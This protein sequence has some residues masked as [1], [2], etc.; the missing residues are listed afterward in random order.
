MKKILTLLILF[1]T[2]F[3]CAQNTGITYQAVIYGPNGQQVPGANNQ[4][5]ILANKTI[6]LQFSIIDQQGQ[7]EYQETIVTTTDK[8][9]MVNLLI[10]VGNQQSGYANGFNDILWNANTKSLKVELDPTQACR[11]FSVISNNPFTYV[12]FAFHSLNPGNPGPQ[13]EQGPIGLT[14]PEGPQGE[15][16]PIG[17]TGP[18][19]PQGEQGP[20]GLT[21]PEGPQGEQG[22]IGLTGPEG[23]QGEQ[24]PIGLTG[25][26]GP[27][28]EQ[29]PIG[30]TGPEGPQGEQ[31]PIGLT[32][33]EGPQGEQGPI[34]L[35]GPEGPQGEQ[36]P[37]GLTGPEGP[38]GEQGPIGLTGPEGPQGEQGP[39]GLTGPEGPQGEQGPIGLTGPEGPQGEQGPIGLTGPEGP[40]GEQG[41]IGL[42][43]PEGPQ[44]EQGPIGLT[45]PEGPQGEQG[46]E[47]LLTSGADAG[48]T[49][50]WDG[51][52]WVVNNSN[53]HNDGAG[54]GIGTTTPN[55]SA[56]VE[57][58]S[59]TQGF[60]PPRLTTVQRDAIA[61][62][63]AGLTIYNTTVNCLQWWNGSIWYD[64]CGNNDPAQNQYP[65]NSVFCA[66]GPTAIVDV[67]NPST[68]KIWMDRNLGASQAAASSADA[69]SYGDLYQW[70][71]R[72]DG[73]QCRN[74]A[75]TTTLSST[76]QPAHGNFI[77]ALNS[78]TDW[79]SPQNAN[80]WQGVNG[81]NNPCP[82]GY[83]LPTEP[84]LDA[85]RLSWGS[86]NAAG[87]FASPL[88]LPMAGYRDNGLGSL[89]NVGTNGSYWSSGLVGG[90]SPYLVF[91]NITSFV[92]SNGRANGYSVRCLKDTTPPAGILGSLDCTSA[93]NNGTLTAGEAASGVNSVVPYTGGNAG[94]HNGQTI[95]STGVTGLTATLS[96]G[97]FA[98]GAGSL[99]YTISGT[100]SSSGTANFALNIGGQSCTLTRTVSLSVGTISSLSCETATN[101]G[102]LT[103]GTTA[104]GVSSSVP[105]TGGNGGTHSGQIV[106]STG[107]TGLTATLSPG[108]FAN[109]V[110][111]LNYTI[112][113]TPNS[114]GTASFAL[115]IGGQECTI[116]I[117]VSGSN[118]NISFLDCDNTINSGGIQV[119]NSFFLM[120][121]I[122]I[123]INLTSE[124]IYLG[125]DGSNYNQITVNSTGVLGLTAFLEAGNF[126]F[127]SGSVTFTITG[128]PQSAGTAN[129]QV[130]IGGIPCSFSWEVVQ[131]ISNSYPNGSVF[132]ASGPT[133]I[134][135]R[136]SLTGKTWMDR[137]LGAT[138]VATSSTDANSG[139]D[140]Y[141]WG[142]RSDGHQCRN[143]AV[144]TTGSGTDQPAHGDFIKRISPPYDW[145]SPQN[146]NLWQGVNGVNN[147]CPSGYRLPTEFELSEERAS[148]SSDDAAGAFG[149]PLKL[150]EAGRRYVVQNLNFALLIG[151]GGN[152][153]SSTVNGTNSNNLRFDGLFVNFNSQNRAHGLSVRCI[154]N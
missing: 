55:A 39:I 117:N 62:P 65:P 148:W 13:G 147:P 41:P 118:P 108:T 80:L 25:P 37:I 8:F 58:A 14:G 27:Q 153:W 88:K 131:N 119:G 10:G 107:V 92:N 7:I 9:G 97:T 30:L 149:S 22:P 63:A 34:G 42:T 94:T 11:E 122:T 126:N 38:Q 129:F 114:S 21:G 128:T 142:R 12:P 90:G 72:S 93:T 57:I 28:G 113:G 150:P 68:G 24:G 134:Q 69:N 51:S 145:R 70:G 111:S 136:V 35:T 85:E 26:E 78:P 71:R 120:Q 49:P 89:V 152:Y 47:G 23:P 67:T 86:N 112:T 104:S 95:T 29:G 2:A 124:I 53:I 125:G 74:S 109:G 98:N 96:P 100:P 115:N 151:S 48:N 59:T 3:I 137:N 102:T 138:Q 99:T 64:G 141:Q 56:K 46:Q 6:C 83:R 40:Q 43:G 61:S 44:G 146:A 87:A 31:G 75:T 20:I 130:T 77:L 54:V 73:H 116:E 143:S 1:V 79:R 66:S 18:E 32:G 17:L 140:L 127:G 123:Q 105:Y 110:G 132:C 15:Q 19:G 33:P 121:N 60:L 154:K 4:Q 82:S 101:T 144:T 139:G 5:F 76:D 50:Y 106:S 16:G 81:I 135:E 91:G 84:E 103:Q 133:I 52:Q 36:G 45:G